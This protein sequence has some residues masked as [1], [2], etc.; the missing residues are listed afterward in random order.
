MLDLDM[1]GLD[2]SVGSGPVVLWVHG[3]DSDHHVW[4]RVIDL[5]WRDFDCVALDLPGHG[6]SSRPDTES[7]YA[8]A[9]VLEAIDQVISDL[10]ASASRRA[11]IWVGH[12]LGGYLGMAHAL[13]RTSANDDPHAI[14]ALVAVATGPGFRDPDAMRDWNARIRVNAPNYFVGE[15]AATIAFH[16]DSMVMDGLG[17]LSLPVALVIGS[18]D[19]AFGGANEYMERKLS[20]VT[21]FTIKG[22]RHFVM[23]S[24]PG[25][26]AEAVRHAAR[27]VTTP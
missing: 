2:M 4:T 5:L 3:V 1:S 8:R 12:S 13:T 7:A 27:L 23:K 20:N 22:G 9:V 14:N 18:E 24:H 21:R 26:V 25:E 10:R 15:T 17:N 6:K 19:H 16:L 11:I